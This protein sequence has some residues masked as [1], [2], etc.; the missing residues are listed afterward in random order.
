MMPGSNGWDVLQH[1]K[2]DP[3]TKNIPVIICTLL[4][5]KEKGL[6]LGAADYLMKPVLEDDLVHA[7]KRLER[8]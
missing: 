7:I 3:A 5:E 1:L 6:N 4:E 8:K 2:S